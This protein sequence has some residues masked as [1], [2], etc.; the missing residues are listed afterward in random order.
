M[1][2]SKKRLALLPALTLSLLVVCTAASVE[3]GA[4]PAGSSSDTSANGLSW[5]DLADLAVTAPAVIRVRIDSVKRLSARQAPDVPN[6]STR[7]LVSVSLEAALKAPNPLPAQGEWLWQGPAGARGRP[8]FDRGE[9]MLAFVRPVPG[10][11]PDVQFYQL[12]TPD[13]QLVWGPQAEADVRDILEQALIPGNQGLMVTGISDGHRSEGNIRGVSES[14]FFL[15]TESGRPLTLSVSR[16]P[17]QPPTLTVATGDFIDRGQPIRPQTLV[18]HALACGLPTELPPNLAAMDGLADDYTL[19]RTEIG[20][21]ARTR[22]GSSGVLIR[23]IA[24]RPQP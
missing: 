6:G 5:S 9:R 7:A 14:Q 17:G 13:A 21:C 4:Q 18:W 22:N 10:G 24:P 23:S 15:S 19:A 3:A 2:I 20:A 1:S 11:G 12:I 16:A 8:P